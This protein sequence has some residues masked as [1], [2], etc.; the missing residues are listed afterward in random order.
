MAREAFSRRA[1]IVRGFGLA[2]VGLA[3]A[4]QW[5]SAQ[6]RAPAAG[7]FGPA[8]E[9]ERYLRL[10]Q[11]SGSAGW[12][13]WS[14]RSFSARELE[15]ILPSDS[16]SIPWRLSP[17]TM[18]SRLSLGSLQLKTVVNSAFPYGSN[19]G[20]IWAGRGLT[21][22]AAAGVAARIGPLSLTLSPIAFIATNNAFALQPNGQAGA[23]AYNHG[24]YPGN[25]DNPQRFGDGAYG[26]VD[27]GASEIRFD[28]RFL[29][30]GFGTAP[31][32]WG[33]A[34]EYPFVIGAN[35]AGFPHAF[36]GTGGPVNV[37]IGKLH[38]RAVWGKLSQSPYSPVVG[39]DRFQGEQEPGRDRLMT[40]LVLVFVPRLTPQLELGVA[41]FAHLPYLEGGVNAEFFQKIWPTFLKKNVGSGFVEGENELASVYARWAFPD[42]GFEIYAEHG[43]DDW[44]NDLR[45]LTQE[46]DHNKSYMIG[47][48]KVMHTSAR[49]ASAVRGELINHVMPPLGRDRPGQGGIYTHG[50][51]RQG[52]TNRGQL[53]GASAGAGS[54]AASV[55]AWDRYTPQGRTTISWQR[56]V[57]AHGGSF[58]TSGVEDSS[59]IDVIHSIGAERSRGSGSLRYTTGLDLMVNFNRNF[60]R[61]A[62]N[63]NARVGMEWSPGRRAARP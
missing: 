36:A 51:H 31:M 23:L 13:P 37:G 7:D 42:V 58:F 46:P 26:R 54:A 50:V 29:T 45:D 53:I 44:Y 25:V 15:K 4:A 57:R 63:L 8:T 33:P 14:I 17:V 39:S 60:E 18:Q 19:D 62:F 34:A 11:I 10:L 38:A 9:V 43:H 59:A 20:A 16:A 30:A 47:F 12:Y 2:L 61:D 52:H 49:V 55:L 40:G 35:A 32:T 27:A 6:S 41:R 22:S 28:S 21:F 1:R 3:F 5:A 56:T 24:L 48:Q